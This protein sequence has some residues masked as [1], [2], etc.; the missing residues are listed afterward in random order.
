VVEGRIEGTASATLSSNEIL[1][2]D[3]LHVRPGRQAPR[4]EAFSRLAGTILA[5]EAR[6]RF[7][8]EAE[9]VKGSFVLCKPW[10]L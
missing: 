10:L 8:V 3:R 7:Q 9:N 1:T 4:L 5:S 2:I 6:I